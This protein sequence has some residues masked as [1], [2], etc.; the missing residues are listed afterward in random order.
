MIDKT[1]TSLILVCSLAGCGGSPP[2]P[3][4]TPSKSEPAS[5]APP[6]SDEEQSSESSEKKEGAKEDEESSESSAKEPAKPTR[7]PKEILTTEGML[8]SFSF[9][10]S[11]LY[12][13][14]EKDCADKSGGDNQKK[15]D[16]MTKA[17]ASVEADS[18][19]FKKEVDGKWT[20]I[21]AR[22][23]GSKVT[24]LHKFEIEFGEETPNSI[25]LK[26]KGRDQGTKR[27]A[28]PAQVQLEVNDS[29]IVV[30]DPKLGK[31]V[32]VGKLGQVGDPGR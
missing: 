9:K 5:E 20:W 21:T 22:R 1:L 16:C 27:M 25:T 26:P 7:S 23:A 17:G 29:G 14:A 24:V 18:M 12:Q 13:K 3:A 11:D 10:D 19:I 4:E 32:Y 31:M 6:P 30:N 2:E 28:T 15:A 8:F